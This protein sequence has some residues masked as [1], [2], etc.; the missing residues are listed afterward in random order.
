MIT[1]FI[2]CPCGNTEGFELATNLAECTS[3][4][5]LVTLTD[6]PIYHKRDITPLQEIAKQQAYDDMIEEQLESMYRR[7]KAG[8]DACAFD[9]GYTEL[10]SDAFWS[11]CFETDNIRVAV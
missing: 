6:T 3:C 5:S 4:T 9:A 8:Q 7:D 1:T 10:E 2:D 11:T